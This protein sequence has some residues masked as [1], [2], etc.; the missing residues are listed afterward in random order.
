VDVDLDGR[1][2]LL[3]S[4][5]TVNLLRNVGNR[6]FA[7]QRLLDHPMTWWGIGDVD[8]DGA[9]DPPFSSPGPYYDFRCLYRLDPRIEDPRRLLGPMLLGLQPAHRLGPFVAADVDGDGR[10]DIVTPS[11]NGVIVNHSLGAGRYRASDECRWRRSC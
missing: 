4:G 5:L 10:V 2:D 9:P 11:S 6:T 1:L 8:D 7:A 3:L